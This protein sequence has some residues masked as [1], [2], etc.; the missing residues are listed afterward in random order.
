MIMKPLVQLA[1]LLLLCV[2]GCDN[3]SGPKTTQTSSAN[4]NKLSDKVAYVEQYVN[5]RR[6]YKKLEFLIDF[7][8]NSGGL[9]PG[10]DDLTWDIRIVAKV[11][12][13][14]L[15]QWTKGL[16]P[17]TSPDVEWLKV[18]PDNIDYSGVSTWFQSGGR[19]VGVDKDNAI[20]VYWNRST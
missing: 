8:N 13:A 20:I 12:T 19:L 4:F 5:F 2:P 3:S 15:A 9:V 14:E 6:T 17:I 11:P 16:Q 10:P 1:M 18:L 7:Q